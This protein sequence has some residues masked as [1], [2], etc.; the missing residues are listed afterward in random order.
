MRGFVKQIVVIFVINIVLLSI[1]SLVSNDLSAA[2]KP[3]KSRTIF[4]QRNMV[5]IKVRANSIEE[6][7]RL[8][9][10]GIDY[11]AI[12]TRIV[13][14]EQSKLE[15]LTEMGINFEIARKALVFKAEGIPLAKGKGEIKHKLE[16][17]DVPIPD[18]DPWGAVSEI[19][20]W[21][22]PYNAVVT[23]V[24]LKIQIVH[25]WLPDVYVKFYDQWSGN[26]LELWDGYGDIW[27]GSDDGYDHDPEDD[28]DIYL[29]YYTWGFN[30]QDVNQTWT[31]YAE[32]QAAEDTGYVDYLEIWLYYNEAGGYY[33]WPLSKC[34]EPAH[35]L[36]SVFGPRWIDNPNNPGVGDS[37]WNFHGGLDIRA[38]YVGEDVYPVFTAVV[39][40]ISTHTVIVQDII[41]STHYMRYHHI[42][43]VLGLNKGDYLIAGETHFAD[44]QNIPRFHLDV[45][46]YIGSPYDR[47]YTR[48]PMHILPYTDFYSMTIWGV[49]SHWPRAA[50]WVTTPGNEL[51]LN[52]VRVYGSGPGWTY[53]KYVDYDE[54]HNVTYDNNY[55]QDPPT[56]NGIKVVPRHFAGSP[57]DKVT[58]FSFRY[59]ARP[60]GIQD[61]II[62]IEVYNIWGV[63]EAS[64]SVEVFVE[65]NE[66][67]KLPKEFFVAQNFPNPFNPETEILYELPKDAQVRLVVYNILGQKV[68]TLVDERQRAGRYNIR[69]EGRDDSGEEVASGVYFYKIQA[70]DIE[71]AKKM[72]LIR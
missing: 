10:M 43:P 28:W 70:G 45:K 23:N 37:V 29:Y 21:D 26:Y 66:D 2:P 33:C 69:W 40:S 32:D 54:K 17:T 49:S 38:G 63:M 60:E 15:E 71:I 11:R 24:D 1:Y 30:G 58:G 57:S 61:S 41:D 44:I 20:V 34:D 52:R 36:T 50:F 4:S 68:K 46:D 42:D 35:G 59:D 65:P 53:D 5:F 67:E 6:V 22:A 55:Y 18:N 12:G 62:T 48:N 8:E 56:V 51:D 27:D 16:D 25:D 39:E 31:L 7:E 13:P 64:Y 9:A 3:R 47:L 19:T 72:L 14:V